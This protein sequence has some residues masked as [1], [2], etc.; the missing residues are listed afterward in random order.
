MVQGTNMNGKSNMSKSSMC[1]A[2]FFLFLP[3]FLGSV[4]GSVNVKDLRCEYLSDPV[5]I[6]TLKPRF[7]WILAC[8]ERGQKQTAYQI[9]VAGSNDNLDKNSGDVWDSGKVK[10]NQSVQVEYGGKEL[11][12]KTK[13]FW[14]VN[15]WDKD[16]N[17]CD[18]G[19]SAT[20]ETGLI[21]ASD[22]LA[23]WIE[24]P[25]RLPAIPRRVKGLNGYHCLAAKDPNEQK[26]L[27]F[28]LHNVFSINKIRLFPARPFDYT[29]DKPGFL[30]PVRYKIDV[31]MTGDFSDS[32]CV[33]DFTKNDISNPG[34]N[35][36]ECL[37]DAVECRF[38]KLTVTR[39]ANREADVYAYALAEVEIYDDANN[40]APN[41][42]V[43]ASDSIENGAW[44]VKN[45][46]DNK[47]KSQKPAPAYSDP[48]PASYFRKEFTAGKA[49]KKARVYSSSLGVYELYI[50]G[51]RIGD[52][53]L[54]P[55]WTNYDKR[56]QYQVYDVASELVQGKN[57]IGATCAEGW[58]GGRILQAVEREGRR[59]RPKLI[60]QLEIE[61]GNGAVKNIV[62]D[63]TWKGTTDG[64]V[65]ASCIYDGEI[66]D[67]RMEMPGW[68]TIDYNDSNWSAVIY[69][70]TPPTESIVSQKCQP[71]RITQLIRSV[72]LSEPSDSVYVFDMGQNFAGICR[73][74]LKGQAGKTVR[75]RYGELLQSDGNIYTDNL[76]N[77]KATD[78]YTMRGGD[79]EFFEPHF[80]YHGFRYVEVIGMENKPA[81][82]DMLGCVIHTDA[83]LSGKFET[84]S[85]LINRIMQNILWTQR[86][87][88]YSIP[89]DCPQRGE[90]RGWMGDA[91]TFAQAACFNMDMSRFFSKYCED[92]AD[93]QT[94]DGDY[95]VFT[96]Q[97]YRHEID[98]CYNAPAW[99]DAGVII[100]WRIYENYA[101]INL[102]RNHFESAKRYVALVAK[103]NPDFI[104]R[105][106]RGR[107]YGD[108]LNADNLRDIP[109]LP[110]KGAG[111][112]RD[113]LAT[114]FWAHS[115]D[116]L[117]KMAGVLG[118]TEDA[119]RYG[120]LSENI[121]KAFNA[122]FVGPDG[123]ITG[124]TQC[125]Y[126]LA[127]HFNLLPENIRQ[128]VFDKMLAGIERYNW[129]ISTG[130]QGTNRMMMELTGFGR[131]DVAYR[132]INNRTVPSWGYMVD[133][134]ATT[135]WER[136]DGYVEG[137]G[138][139]RGVHCTLM[140]S[141][142][143]YG[144]GAVGEWMWRN[145]AGINPDSNNPGYKHF[146]IWP[147]PGGGLEWA[148]GEYNSVHGIIIS[149]WEIR[150]GRFYLN[151]SVP[152]N[153]T[154][155]VYLPAKNKMDIMEGG[156]AIKQTGD[157][158]FVSFE[159]ETAIFR[160][161]SGVYN[162]ESICN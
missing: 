54:S 14:K 33:A 147:R 26:W 143:H 24:V 82:N 134:N 127:L 17:L 157:V 84:S 10:S 5:G 153:T 1:Y 27:M 12:S 78:Y 34:D 77:A 148:K 37:F 69:L 73:M 129:H 68:N 89:T 124:D 85:P 6:D 9:L 118:K 63:F 126:A 61:Y 159:N 74:K 106:Q 79:E 28:D 137:R 35:F 94:K 67:A 44:S 156:K 121:K 119:R 25:Y 104:W 76:F 103:R 112:P 30:F 144:L 133:C 102:L 49:I 40:I 139:R 142:N 20:F 56:V 15:V 66:Y 11:K 154:A 140:N 8:G 113:V 45:I 105:N 71:M 18:N 161:S 2:A 59:L 91:Q 50:N 60:V 3:I 4:S 93:A 120:L 155:T 150:D 101:D 100:P 53:I 75:F 162:F 32:T 111:V 48:A 88:M 31:S 151:I 128:K 51:K 158:Q 42:M 122:E 123:Q 29:V 114:A 99:T 70:I 41:A 46:N 13:Y 72:K 95:P 62:S 81:I 57:V 116:L 36:V 22:W 149:D 38:V 39:L 125:G 7:S 52:D 21:N 109:G 80:T 108:W 110:K 135:I 16:G 98:S 83:P 146:I 23:Y 58:Y 97:P 64:P 107:D 132:L 141:F 115:A 130:I 65:R 152:A 138:V 160:V 55:G 47:N 92:I 90:R 117:A 131:N 86:S 145:I 96:P 43:T 19:Q 136:W 87:N